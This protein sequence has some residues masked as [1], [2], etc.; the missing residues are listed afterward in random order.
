MFMGR[1]LR[2]QLG[3]TWGFRFHKL[4][5]DR[6][7]GLGALVVRAPPAE[8]KVPASMERLMAVVCLEG[9]QIAQSRD[10]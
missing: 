6:Q 9:V 2:A 8:D 3:H 10:V 1:G 5:T 4:T 7:F